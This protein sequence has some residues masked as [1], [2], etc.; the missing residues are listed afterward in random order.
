MISLL[1]DEQVKV[2]QREIEQEIDAKEIV[3]RNILC[4]NSANFQ[5][6]ERDVVFLSLV[7][8]GDGTGP[9]SMM[10]FGVDDAMRK[11]YN[12]AASR[13]RD[14]LWVVHSLDAAN[15]LK[16][17]DMRKRLIDYAANPHALDVQ[18]T[19]IEAHSESPF[20]LAV[21]TNLSDRGYHLVQ[22]WKVGA[23]RLD[24]VALCGKKMVAIECDGERW[25]SGEE[26]V[27]EDMER[28]TIL[29][30]LGWRF[31]RI[32]GSEY[33]RA[34]EETMERVVSEL[35][36]FGIEPETAE[37]SN[38]SEQRTS[39]LL[40]RVKLRAAQIIE[41]K[42]GEDDSI[43]LETIRIALDPKSIVPKQD[44]EKAMSAQMVANVEQVTVDVQKDNPK[45]PAVEVTAAQKLPHERHPKNLPLQNP[46]KQAIRKRKT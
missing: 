20:E 44:E 28:Q 6:D 15:D 30:R 26:K 41:S 11:R 40:S 43:D 35:T 19:E 42:H 23:Y 1:G 5:G 7:D 9:L 39:E 17:G 8:S 18:H 36:A 46:Q 33:Y 4:G 22:Q 29:E 14:Q 24:M 3:S 38:S 16:P 2:I 31:I 12:V 25:H 32:R 10:G 27:R 13:A 45:L 21:A 37:D 34:P